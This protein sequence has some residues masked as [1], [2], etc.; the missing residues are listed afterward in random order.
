MRRYVRNAAKIKPRNAEIVDPTEIAACLA[1]SR[2]T[3]L[4]K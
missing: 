4:R 1:G 3:S 2:E